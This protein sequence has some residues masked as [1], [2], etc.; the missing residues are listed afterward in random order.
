MD[1]TWD[2]VKLLIPKKERMRGIYAMEAEYLS[3]HPNSGYLTEIL[4]LK[5]FPDYID[6]L[7][8]GCIARKIGVMGYLPQQEKDASYIAIS[9]DEY[10][11]FVKNTIQLVVK[12]FEEKNLV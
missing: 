12:Q 8:N 6:Y 10:A 11:D 2:S 4:P 7:P 9:Q 1:E 3:D 5:S